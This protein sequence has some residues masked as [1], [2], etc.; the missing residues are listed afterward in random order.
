MRGKLVVGAV[1]CLTIHGLASASQEPVD[2]ASK[3]IEAL[4]RNAPIIREL[5]GMGALDQEMRTRF[6]ALR[7]NAS[8]E[9]RRALDGVW[10]RE[11]E[12]ID[13]QHVMRLKALLNGRGWF[14]AEQVGDRASAA[15]FAIVIHS[16]DV[17]FQREALAK[18]EALSAD[19]RPSGY[20]ILFDR[21][22]VE[23]GRPQRYG[24][25]RPECLDGKHARPK[26]IE[27]PSHLDAR[28]RSAGLQPF[29]EY[30]ALLDKMYGRC[31]PP[32]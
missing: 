27:D 28:R 9:D 19:Q 20:A 4:R 15:A 12:P 13:Q 8:D 6:L 11:F 2:A 10:A 30:L 3:A 26:S 25:Q 24:T 14:T 1:L 21:M 32:A 22:A 7:Q 18:M 16:N 23:D 17:E 29:D 31:S 5:A